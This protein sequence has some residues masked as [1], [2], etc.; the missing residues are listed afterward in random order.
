[1]EQIRTPSRLA[2][3]SVEPSPLASCSSLI[4]DPERPRKIARIRR[5]I[6]SG[7]YHVES[8]DIAAKLIEHMY[9]LQPG[10]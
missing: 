1:M 4:D 6:K 9:R 2:S 8:S 7:R 10:H 3:P 5:A